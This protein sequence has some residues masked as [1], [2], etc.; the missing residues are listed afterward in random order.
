M[1]SF[2]ESIS[3]HPSVVTK[4]KSH[5][6]SRVL[7]KLSQPANTDDP[8][9]HRA[10]PAVKGPAKRAVQAG[11]HREHFAF[12]K[13]GLDESKTILKA[14]KKAKYKVRDKV[15]D[16]IDKVAYSGDDAYAKKVNQIGQK[17]LEPVTS[18]RGWRLSKK[19]KFNSKHKKAIADYTAGSAGLNQS[20]ATG[21]GEPHHHPVYKGM[22]DA[23]KSNKTPKKLTVY[24]GLGHRR[25]SD[26]I[27]NAGK[28]HIHLKAFTSTSL[29]KETA[30]TFTSS[31]KANG[32][33]GY[34][35]RGH[36]YYRHI[37]KLTVPKGS[38]AAYVDKHSEITRGSGTSEHEVTL[39]P[40]ARVHVPKAGKPEKGSDYII[41]HGTLVHDGI[42]PTDH[43][44]KG[45][46]KSFRSFIAGKKKK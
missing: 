26:V 31:V 36:G 13:E 24:T 12:V 35:A 28:A 46:L 41:H 11:K 40:G 37:L 44:P 23:I 10:K 39:H 32:D 7:H 20:I 25:A 30:K 38:H 6:I 33:N 21:E 34:G 1:K 19:Q 4:I 42:K 16:H 3:L 14:L 43:K 27:H 45:I 17:I 5:N 18:F 22:S 9:L 29:S 2:K 15:S 8:V